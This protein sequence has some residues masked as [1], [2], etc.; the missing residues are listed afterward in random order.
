MTFE[1]SY[2]ALHKIFEMEKDA[3]PYGIAC[4]AVGCAMYIGESEN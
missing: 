3:H 4:I 2:G 1:T